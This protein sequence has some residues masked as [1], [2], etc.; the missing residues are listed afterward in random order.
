MLLSL[1]NVTVGV[2][3]GDVVPAVYVDL[4][5]LVPAKVLCENR[6]FSHFGVK[7]VG[8][9]LEAHALNL[10]SA[11]VEILLDVG[12]KLDEFGAVGQ[13]RRVILGNIFLGAP[14]QL[15]KGRFP[16][17]QIT[18]FTIPLTVEMYLLSLSLSDRV[19]VMVCCLIALE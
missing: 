8:H 9:I 7:P 12:A 19:P 5:D 3:D 16:R 4:L 13:C 1:L 17:H 6:V 10:I 14:K 15:H 2:G 11:V 18:A